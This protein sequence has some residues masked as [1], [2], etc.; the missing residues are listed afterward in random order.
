MLNPRRSGHKHKKNS[1]TSSYNKKNFNQINALKNKDRC[2]K[3]RDSTHVEG[4]QCPAKKFQ[5]KVCH[6]CGHFTILYY[7]KKQA[8]FKP[9][10]PKAHQ[11]QAGTVYVQENAIC[12]HSKDYSS[13]DDSFCLQIQVQCTQTNPKNFPTPTHL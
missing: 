12:G 10:R 8:S 11:L 4:F 3:Y 5:C 13:S 9:R 7:Q 6:K 2:L 1:Q